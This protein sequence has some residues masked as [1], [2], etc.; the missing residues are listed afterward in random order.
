MGEIGIV[1]RECPDGVQVF[2]QDE[3]CNGFKRMLFVD[4][5]VNVAEVLDVIYQQGWSA[6]Q[7]GLR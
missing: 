3:D 6:G 1:L 5:A 4:T 2:R 7:R